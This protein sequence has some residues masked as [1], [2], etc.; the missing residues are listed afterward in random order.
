MD[1]EPLH[2]LFVYPKLTPSLNRIDSWITKGGK[3]LKSI[4][5]EIDI[6]QAQEVAREMLK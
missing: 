3:S 1:R 4:L 6:M 2:D 5:E